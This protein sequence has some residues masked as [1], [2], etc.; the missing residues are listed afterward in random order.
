MS[1]G[2]STKQSSTRRT[3]LENPG[4]SKGESE[5]PAREEEMV[6]ATL[7]PGQTLWELVLGG[8]GVITALFVISSPL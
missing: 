3:S 4:A 1:Q 6:A 5:I 2:Q 7:S 8:V